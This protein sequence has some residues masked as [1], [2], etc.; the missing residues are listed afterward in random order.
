MGD[1]MTTP[2]FSF[3]CMIEWCAYVKLLERGQISRDDIDAYFASNTF[4]HV[5]IEPDNL[6]H[7]STDDVL[8]AVGAVVNQIE[9]WHSKGA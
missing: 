4:H 2:R 9:I 8:L 3:Q 1:K 7:P 5:A 6:D